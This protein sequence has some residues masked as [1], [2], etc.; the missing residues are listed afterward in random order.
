MSEDGTPNGATPAIL[1]R[2]HELE[3]RAQSHDDKLD[4]VQA[5]VT[6]LLAKSCPFPGS[7]VDLLRRLDVVEKG[8]AFLHDAGQRAIGA[9]LAIKVI[10]IGVG[11]AIVAGLA[12]LLSHLGVHAK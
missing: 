7:C 6:Q 1:V 5:D 8:V 9:G 12:W 11:G 10:W 3:R 2:L 4:K